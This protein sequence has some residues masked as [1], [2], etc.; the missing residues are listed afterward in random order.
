MRG[1]DFQSVQPIQTIR[2][3]MSSPVASTLLRCRW[4]RSKRRGIVARMAT[5]VPAAEQD[6]PWKEALDQFL[7]P[8]L[9]FFFPDLHQDIDWTRPYQALDKEF[10]Q[11]IRGAAAGK[12]LADKLYKVWL[13]T[14]SE[15]W[16][17]IHIEIQ[18]QVDPKFPERMFDYNQRAYQLY[19]RLV[20]SLALLCDEDPDWRPNYFGYGGWGSTMGL[21]FR[22]A[23]LLD[24]T[25]DREALERS[26]NPIA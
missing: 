15:L 8:F 12:A 4:F 7:N 11:I 16:I 22:P 13:K 14:G 19:R 5:S 23:K 3:T 6:A 25:G 18:A 2:K 10:Q 20:I 26:K 9:A 1:T 17:I 24:Y 21:T